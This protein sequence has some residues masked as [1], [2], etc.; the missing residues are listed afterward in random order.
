MAP[1]ALPGV[2]IRLVPEVPLNRFV[3]AP[4]ALKI[5][6]SIAYLVLVLFI[7]FAVRGRREHAQIRLP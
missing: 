1:I 5:T 4:N 2:N 7:V 6:L 3:D